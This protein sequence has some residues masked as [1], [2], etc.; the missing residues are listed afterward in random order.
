[1]MKI[2]PDIKVEIEALKKTQT[3]GKLE[4]KNLGSQPKLQRYA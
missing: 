3:K 4:M 2:I 1:M